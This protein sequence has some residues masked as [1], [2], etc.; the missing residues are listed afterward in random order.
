MV[1]AIIALERLLQSKQQAVIDAGAIV[2]GG[3]YFWSGIQKFNAAF[4]LE[5]FPWFTHHL[6]SPFGEVGQ[7]VFGTFGIV[8]PFLE[9]GLAIGLFTR[10]FRTISIFG[11]FAMLLVVL[12]SIGPFGHAWNAA[13]WPWNIAIFLSIVAVFYG[14][15]DTFRAFVL[16]QRH[17]YVSVLVFFIFWLMPLGNLIG[18]TDHYLSWSLYSGRV[19]TATIVANEAFLQTL[20]PENNGNELPFERWTLATMNVA[21]YPEARVFESIFDSLC[22]SYPDEHLL[23]QIKTPRFF[24]STDYSLTTIHCQ[25]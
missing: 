21:P 12:T 9:A 8:V 13:V 2:L 23:L 19:P 1:L 11:T 22:K 3:I 15:T 6:W 25:K 17:Q 20:S 24:V 18:L 16:R 10:R 5:V 14:N 7:T 4:F